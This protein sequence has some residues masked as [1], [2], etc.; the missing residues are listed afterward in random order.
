MKSKEEIA[1]I[2]ADAKSRLDQVLNNIV[3]LA[4]DI[5]P[6]YDVIEDYFFQDIDYHKIS[7]MLP[8]W[9]SDAGHSPESPIDKDTYEKMRGVYNDPMSNRII[10]WADVQ[11]VLAAFQDRIMAVYTFLMEIYKYLPAYCLF[12]DT[13]YE[14]STRGLDDTSDHVYISINNVFVSLCSS[15]D[16]FTKVI[17]ECYHYDINSFVEYKKMKSRKENIL[18]RKGFFFFF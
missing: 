1:Y 18:Y 6:L 10:H 15:F 13:D 11:A 2:K 12:D 8:L 5:V 14:S 3:A 9:M 7:P 17:Y 16:L 4:E